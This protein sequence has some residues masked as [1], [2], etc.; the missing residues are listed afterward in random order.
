MATHKYEE[1]QYHDTVVL[2]IYELPTIEAFISGN[3]SICA[4]SEEN[5][6]VRISFSGVPPFTFMYSHNGENKGPF[7]TTLNPYVIQTKSAS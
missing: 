3:D 5:A 1:Q 4:N 6:E 2:R 7:T